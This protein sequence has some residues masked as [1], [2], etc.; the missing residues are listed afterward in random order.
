MVAYKNGKKWAENVVATTDEPVRLE[1]SADREEI[2]ANGNDL[3]FITVRVTDKNGLTG[4]TRD[5]SNRVRDPGNGEIVA[6]DNGDPT[7]FVPFPS[8]ERK[9]FNGLALI[10]VRSK[11]REPG[12]ITVTA[13]SPGLKET[14]IIVR[15]QWVRK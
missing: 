4:T 13:E 8:H 2:R 5:E 14:Q 15:S 10:I 1:A 3:A 7:N 6:T 9:A 12:S 11:P